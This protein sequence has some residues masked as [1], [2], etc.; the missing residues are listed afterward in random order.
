M[1]IDIGQMLTAMEMIHTNIEEEP[2]KPL[3][4]FIL[5]CLEACSKT[6]NEQM[7]LETDK[8]RSDWEGNSFDDEADPEAVFVAKLNNKWNNL[9]SHEEKKKT[10]GSTSSSKSTADPVDEKTLALFHALTHIYCSVAISASTDHAEVK[11]INF[12]RQP[13]IWPTGGWNYY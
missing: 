13:A 4:D 11:W 9:T 7:K 1:V 8:I 5:Y 6:T 10:W 2:K 12:F 3:V